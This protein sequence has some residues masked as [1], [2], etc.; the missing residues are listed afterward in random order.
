LREL[1]RFTVDLF[2]GCL[3]VGDFEVKKS[4][5]LVRAS[6]YAQACDNVAAGTM[7]CRFTPKW[8]FNPCRAWEKPR[9][10]MQLCLGWGKPCQCD[11]KMKEK[12]RKIL[13]RKWRDFISD[14]AG[15][16]VAMQVRTYLETTPCL[17]CDRC[18]V[19]V[20]LG[21]QTHA[22]SRSYGT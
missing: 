20:E 2:I 6:V 12:K 8:R 14:V 4:T 5:L 15:V 7:D 21:K 1:L 9:F 11:L 18:C 10:R 17:R 22:R 3:R 19:S 16:W 13:F